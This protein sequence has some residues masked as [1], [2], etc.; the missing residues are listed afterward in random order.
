MADVDHRHPVSGEAPDQL[1][2]AIHILALES[3]RRLVH[4]ENA[5]VRRQGTADL[6][7]LLRGDG[8]RADAPV[9]ME[10]RV[11]EVLEQCQRP[12]PRRVSVDPPPARRL[13]AEQDVLGYREVGAQRKLLMNQGDAPAP[14]VQR[15]VG[16]VQPSLDL[17][18]APIGADGAGQD[19]H[20]GAL[21]GAG[22]AEPLGDASDLEQTHCSVRY[23]AIGGWMTSCVA[24]ESRFAP[25]TSMT[26][27]SMRRSTGLPRR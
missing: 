26:P 2:Q 9:R 14:R 27:V 21:A 4:E 12:P 15:R 6:D 13:D 10:V 22:R 19:I 25:V 3:A 24:A 1:E 16:G 7:Y 23:R 20:E 5:R 18:L 8:E 17:H 11:T